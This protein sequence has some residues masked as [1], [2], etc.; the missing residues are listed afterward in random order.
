MVGAWEGGDFPK[1]SVPKKC[2]GFRLIVVFVFSQPLGMAS[3]SG[4]LLLLHFPH[5]ARSLFRRSA[6]LL[7]RGADPFSMVRCLRRLH[8]VQRASRGF[9]SVPL[10]TAQNRKSSW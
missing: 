9:P 5:R 1:N 6:H 7:V 10:Q 3:D 8:E 4:R 2:L